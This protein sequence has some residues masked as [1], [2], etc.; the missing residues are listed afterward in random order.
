M[1][2]LPLKL[3][4]AELARKMNKE[5]A[6]A[7]PRQLTLLTVF[8]SWEINISKK[9]NRQIFLAKLIKKYVITLF[10]DIKSGDQNAYQ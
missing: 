8:L 9:E 3:V 5:K 10:K 7:G 4:L 6:Y 2:F 1:R